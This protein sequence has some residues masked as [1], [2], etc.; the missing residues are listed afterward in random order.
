MIATFVNCVAVIIGSLIGYFFHSRISDSMKSIVYTGAGLVSL[1]LGMRM[2]FATNRI[3]YLALALI[4][5][6]LVGQWLNIEGGILRFGTF[7]KKRFATGDSERDFAYG[8]LDASV[9]FCVGAMTLI[10][11]FKAGAEGDYELLLTK[12]VLDGFM[13]IAFSAALGIGVA[14]SAITV[15][16]YQGS[17]TLLARALQPYASELVLGELTGVG[18]VLVIMIGINLLG[19]AKLKTANYLPALVLILVL[20]GLESVIPKDWLFF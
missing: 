13:A 3:V 11:S 16:V 10:G 17:L 9:L 7:L 18:G 20:L 5:G 1:V 4:A 6:G 19:L 14:F 2:A 12:S 8:Y 15:L